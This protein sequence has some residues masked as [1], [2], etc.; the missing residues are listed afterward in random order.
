MNSKLTC[1]RKRIPG[2]RIDGQ[3]LRPR[4]HGLRTASGR[5]DHDRVQASASPIP[6][7]LEDRDLQGRAAKELSVDYGR[8]APVERHT[9]INQCG[10]DGVVVGGEP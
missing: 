9:T 8:G 6:G 1:I 3:R 7:K 2:N 4:F 10:L 5:D